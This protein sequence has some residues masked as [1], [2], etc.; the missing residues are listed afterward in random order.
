M[1]QFYSQQVG[2]IEKVRQLYVDKL[3]LINLDLVLKQFSSIT[4]PNKKPNQFEIDH[5]NKLIS[6]IKKIDI[7]TMMTSLS[8]A[9]ELENSHYQKMVD[10][11]KGY[12]CSLCSYAAAKY[13]DIVNQ[14]VNYSGQMC[15]NILHQIY[16]F[17]NKKS[18]SL[19]LILLLYDEIFYL[20]FQ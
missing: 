4:D 13:I 15:L 20:L 16:P 6:Y 1:N 12:Y 8:N 3:S 19:Y 7:N 18:E 14:N 5:L 10:I 9:V 17:A 2:E 11:R